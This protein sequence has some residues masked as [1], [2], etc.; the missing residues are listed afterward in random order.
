MSIG[1][2][3]D[4]L[5]LWEWTKK[6]IAYLCGYRLHLVELDFSLQQQ[7]LSEL[8]IVMFVMFNPW[9]TDGQV[10]SL[11][12]IYMERVCFEKLID[13]YPLYLVWL[14][15]SWFLYKTTIELFCNRNSHR[16]VY[17]PLTV[18]CP[19]LLQL[20]VEFYAAAGNAKILNPTEL[21]T[22]PHAHHTLQHNQPRSFH[23][24][25][26]HRSGDQTLIQLKNRPMVSHLESFV[27]SQTTCGYSNIKLMS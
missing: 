15:R 4:S 8:R 22:H 21:W 13:L 11:G 10:V 12:Y 5:V 24:P 7:P 14:I 2:G 18:S 6:D 20:L 1:S 9:H 3:G 23:K 25:S 16:F 19:H 27:F 17:I 26:C